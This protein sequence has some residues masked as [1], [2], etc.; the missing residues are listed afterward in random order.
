MANQRTVD[1]TIT[2]NGGSVGPLEFRKHTG[3]HRDRAQVIVTG[4]FVG[5]LEVRVCTPG[6]AVASGAPDATT[7]DAPF[8]S[9][10]EPGGDCDLYVYASAWTSG[11]ATVAFTS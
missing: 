8:A 7:Y 2:A 3:N 9:T 5:T 1:G 6:Q 10:I 4:T 11:T